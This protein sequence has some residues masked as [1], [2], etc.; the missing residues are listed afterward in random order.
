MA[1]A[2]SVTP[3]E[4]TVISFLRD[5]ETEAVVRETMPLEWVKATYRRGGLKDAI[6]QMSDLESPDVLIIDISDC[7]NDH[8]VLS[9]L[10]ALAN[11]IEPDT[12]VVAVG[13]NRDVTFYRQLTRVMGVA[14]LIHKPVTRLDIAHLLLPVLGREHVL[15]QETR[16]GRIIA[17]VGAKGGVGATTIATGL[18]RYMSD[19]SHRHTLVIDGDFRASACSIFLRASQDMPFGLRQLL[20]RPERIDRLFVERAT[21][22]IS[23]R[24]DLLAAE[25]KPTTPDVIPAGAMAPLMEILRLRYNFVVIDLPMDGRPFTTDC[26]AM[27]NHKVVV[28]DPSLVG[29]KAAHKILQLDP[30]P[31]EP[32]RPTVV[33]NRAGAKGGI[34]VDKLRNTGDMKIDIEIP[35]LGAAM[36]SAA[37][38]TGDALDLKPF[39]GA[40]ETLAKE[41]GGMD[42][43]AMAQFRKKGGLFSRLGRR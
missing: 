29:L 42:A 36:M 35:D 43:Q 30:G 34:P 6:I 11:L 38:L 21:A 19:I 17:V 20:E 24:L 15:A 33:L 14:E 9:T 31:V 37:N 27:T 8:S 2:Q 26:L 41:I 7:E 32:Q 39:R 18:A 4:K 10:E 16:G 22:T 13:L 12:A 3:T 40:I 23:D 5:Q 25:E 28:M 1:D